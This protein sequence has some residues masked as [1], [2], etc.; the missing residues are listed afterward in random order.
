MLARLHIGSRP[1]FSITPLV[2][3]FGIREVRERP[4]DLDAR[5]I[6]QS[7]ELLIEVNSLFP[8]VRRRLSIAHE[9]GHLIVERC[10]EDPNMQWGHHDPAIE[11]LCNR[12]AG[13]LLAPD[14]ALEQHFEAEYGLADWRE[15][16]RCTTVISVASK[17]GISVDT[18]A[19]R[20][21]CELG[22]APRMTAIIWRHRENTVRPGSDV[23]LRIASA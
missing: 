12:L 16:V 7:G 3:H 8:L 23:A 19:S 15:R 18:A 20:I 14:W 5:L 1:P 10:S 17:F 4:L 13:G 11:A 21:F 9:I 6:R 22:L 2:E